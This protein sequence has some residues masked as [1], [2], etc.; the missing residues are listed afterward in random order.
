MASIGHVAIGMAAGRA[1]STDPKTAR[2]AMFVLSAIS[3]WPDID[4][5]GFLIGIPYG[6]S[7]GH[8]GATHSIAVA[9]FVGLASYVYAQRKG[10]APKR[11]AEIV[12]LVAVSHPLLDT[13]TYGGGYGCAL[14]WP[15]SDERFWS[16][17]RF[18][19]IA[20][21]GL[22]LLSAR[23]LTVMAAE[24]VIFSPFFAYA[25]W[26]RRKPKPS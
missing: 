22:R 5:V 8:R 15:F 7:L 14:F 10:L 9:L 23:G 13:M 26:P 16:P 6:A 2:R 17:L 12:T 3:L 11:T 20:P 19:P 25:L 4:A 21:I 1:F 24:V 18:I